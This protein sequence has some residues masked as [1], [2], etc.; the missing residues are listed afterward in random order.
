MAGRLV[1]CAWFRPREKLLSGNREVGL[2]VVGKP[3]AV[4]FGPGSTTCRHTHASGLAAIRPSAKNLRI[5]RQTKP[6]RSPDFGSGL[7]RRPGWRGEVWQR[8][9]EMLNI[10]WESFERLRLRTRQKCRETLQMI[11]DIVKGYHWFV[12]WAFLGRAMLRTRLPW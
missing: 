1:L 8:C 4:E 9:E 11:K 5:R 12:P 3:V 7:A 6:D 10:S 2:R